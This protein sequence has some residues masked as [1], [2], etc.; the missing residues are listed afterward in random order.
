MPIPC[1]KINT[2]KRKTGRQVSAPPFGG[3][4]SVNLGLGPGICILAGSDSVVKLVLPTCEP[5]LHLQ[6]PNKAESS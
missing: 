6:P 2:F 4:N 1:T 3:S 5:D